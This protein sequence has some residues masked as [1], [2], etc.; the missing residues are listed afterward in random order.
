LSIGTSRQTAE[1]FRY[2]PLLDPFDYNYDSI[3][4]LAEWWRGQAVDQGTPDLPDWHKIDKLG[5]VPW[6]GWLAV[7]RLDWEGARVVD[8]CF[9][10]V[11]TK[12]V[13]TAGYDLTGARLSERSYSL[14]PDIVIG[15]LNR[16]ARHG[17]PAVQNNLIRI[18]GDYAELSDRLWLP[19]SDGAGTVG[20]IMIYMANVN[21]LVDRFDSSRIQ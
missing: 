15:N 7:Y 10:L 17:K 9:R 5:L 8:A 18:L 14:T 2:A 13:D 16:I 1:T 19:F 21:V 20:T 4:R 3:R 12:I 11:G 6:M